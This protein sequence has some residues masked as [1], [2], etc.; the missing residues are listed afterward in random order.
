M[1]KDDPGDAVLFR[2]KAAWAKWLERHHTQ[3]SGVWLKHAKARSGERS[4]SYDE[5]LDVAL[6][7]GWIDA[8]GRSGGD[9]FSLQRWCP[10]RKRSPWSKRN[11]AKAEALIAS[12][13]MQPAGLAEIERAKADGRWAAAYDGPA[14][15]TVPAE[16]RAALDANPE[17]KRFFES[18]D[19]R[20]RYAIL[21]RLQTAKKPETVTR[22]IER[23]VEMLAKG[24]KI[25]P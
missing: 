19:G 14:T 8:Q 20:N 5:A 15:A 17:A 6:C 3:E 24:E 25:Y 4:V 7:Y 21:H 18:L 9:L 16:L 23:F 1:P 2:T 11:V 10:R 22:R 13:Q 12:G